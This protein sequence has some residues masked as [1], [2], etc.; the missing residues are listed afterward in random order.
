MEALARELA[1]PGAVA[2]AVARTASIRDEITADPVRTA[3]A[4]T[5]HRAW[6]DGIA[7]HQAEVAAITAHLRDQV[8]MRD[9]YP[10]RLA[11]ITAAIDTVAAAEAGTGEAFARA[12]GKIADA[13]LPPVPDA[14]GVLRHRVSELDT[15]Y[16]RARAAAGTGTPVEGGWGQLV[17]DAELIEAQVARAGERAAELTAAADG[18][19]GRRDELRGRLEAYR[20]KAAGHRLDEHEELAALHTDA[21][22][23]LYTAPCDLPAATRAVFAYQRALAGLLEAGDDR[24]RTTR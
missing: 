10:Q 9:A 17:R 13:G 14:A 4:G 5:L 2:H 19:I 24:K 8:R 15:A 7:K 22:D 16:A 6:R 3:P 20:A 23:R 18:L 21:H 11:Q 1:D 12:T